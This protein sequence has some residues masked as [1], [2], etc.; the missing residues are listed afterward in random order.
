MQC[1]QTQHRGQQG[2]V[3]Q[4]P[5]VFDNRD[6]AEVG[7]QWTGEGMGVENTEMVRTDYLPLDDKR[8]ALDDKR[9]RAADDGVVAGGAGTGQG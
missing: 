7:W 4:L 5:T 2:R 6:F 1:V 3:C 8:M 9:R